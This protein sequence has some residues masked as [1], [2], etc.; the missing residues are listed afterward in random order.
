MEDV[1]SRLAQL[2]VKL[3]MTKKEGDNGKD[4]RRTI[5]RKCC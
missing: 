2:T 3:R 5:S 4:R 1:V